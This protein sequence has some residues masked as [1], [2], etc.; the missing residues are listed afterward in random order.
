MSIQTLVNCPDV[1]YIKI[2]EFV[3]IKITLNQKLLKI[4]TKMKKCNIRELS[5]KAQTKAEIYQILTIEGGLYLP[6]QKD[7]NMKFIR[8]I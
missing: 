7:T 8:Q 4:Q 5:T 1:N 3:L 6:P 2:R